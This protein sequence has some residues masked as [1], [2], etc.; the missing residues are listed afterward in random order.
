VVNGAELVIDSITGFVRDQ[1]YLRKYALDHFS[2]PVRKATS[3]ERLEPFERYRR[4]LVKFFS[5]Q[6]PFMER[7]YLEQDGIEFDP[8]LLEFRPSEIVYLDGLWQSE[9][10][11]LDIEGT[12]RQDLRIPP[13]NDHSNRVM[14]EKIRGSNSVALHVRWFDEPNAEAGHNLGPDYYV[15]AIKHIRERVLNPHFFLFSDDPA[16]AVKGLALPVGDFTCILHNQG[17]DKAFADLWLMTQCRHFITANSTF[18]WWGAW[19][20]EGEG[21]LVLAPGLKFHGTT[22]A[23]GF[24]GLLPE[25]WT[26]IL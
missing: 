24:P 21:K 10:Y 18:S 1:Q 23:W 16:A 19:L 11:F 20:G 5:R 15:K 9:N 3:A 2:I 17:E 22:T 6:R 4:G 26:L 7:R 12:I 13:P 14:S 25:R 8:R